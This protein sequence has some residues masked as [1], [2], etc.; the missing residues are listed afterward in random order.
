LSRDEFIH[1]DLLR[2]GETEGGAR[3][4]GVTDDPLTTAGWEQM[5]VAIKDDVYWESI[6]SSPLMRCADFARVLAQRRS[7]PLHID[8]RLREIDFG[9]WES[10]SAAE[11]METEPN[12]LARFWQDP[13]NNRPPSGEPLPQM[14]SRVLAAWHEIIAKQRSVLLISHGGP[15]RVILCHLQGHPL[16]RLLEIDVP[17]AALHRLRVRTGDMART[18][19]LEP[20]EP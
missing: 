15:I 7:L 3:Y 5:S 13:W 16:D 2:H 4:R 6:I 10:R 12:A 1:I 14:R 17:H 11:L 19:L 20:D 8:E 18:L 9:T